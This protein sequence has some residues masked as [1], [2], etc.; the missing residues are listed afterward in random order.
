MFSLKAKTEVLR[1]TR[2]NPFLLVENHRVIVEFIKKSIYSRFSYSYV[3]S[4]LRPIRQANTV[5]TIFDSTLTT[6]SGV[7]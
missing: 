4:M 6:C 3:R 7:A 1:E 2:G 5:N